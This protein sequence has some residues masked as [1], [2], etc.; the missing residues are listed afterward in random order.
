MPVYVIFET[1]KNALYL[2]SL[3]IVSK[4]E[5]MFGTVNSVTRC[6]NKKI[7]K[8]LQKLSKQQ[9][10]ISKLLFLKSPISH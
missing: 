5:K 6:W 3:I 7:P 1:P 9:L 8:F 4:N 2:F 10:L